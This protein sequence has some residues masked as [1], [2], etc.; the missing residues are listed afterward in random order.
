MAA[1]GVDKPAKNRNF[2]SSAL[3][4]SSVANRDRASSSASRSSGDSVTSPDPE[5][6]RALVRRHGE[7]ASLAAGRVD[8]NSSHGLRSRGEKVAAMIPMLPWSISNQSKVGLVNQGG[9]LSVCPGFSWA[10][11]WAASRAIRRTLAAATG[12]QHVDHRPR[13]RE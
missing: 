1:S 4:G 13:W 5:A 6:A 11:R 9:R 8:E 3:A 12:P 2:T 7:I 10:N